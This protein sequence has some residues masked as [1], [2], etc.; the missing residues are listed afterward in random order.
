MSPNSSDSA[1]IP[2]PDLVPTCGEGGV[3]SRKRYSTAMDDVGRGNRRTDVS[4]NVW[5]FAEERFVQDEVTRTITRTSADADALPPER[6]DPPVLVAKAE[7]AFISGCPRSMPP[8]PLYRAVYCC[9]SSALVVNQPSSAKGRTV[10]QSTRFQL[11]TLSP[12]RY[13]SV[14]TPGPRTAVT[15]IEKRRHRCLSARSFR[16]TMLLVT[17]DWMTFCKV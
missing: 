1:A 11:S 9:Q 16:S 6:S 3:P 12:L 7:L 14:R 17:H 4:R 2:G 13:L 10:P 5:R 8:P 15:A